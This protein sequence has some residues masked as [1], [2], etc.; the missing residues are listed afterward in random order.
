M[1]V[2]PRERDGAQVENSGEVQNEDEGQH[3]GQSQQGSDEKTKVGVIGW[4]NDI[5]GLHQEWAHVIMRRSI[6][7]M[8]YLRICLISH[9][10]TG[11]D[12]RK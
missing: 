11:I 10:K 4:R 6:M 9:E 8:A 7:S 3:H 12:L 2:W 5:C 1:Q